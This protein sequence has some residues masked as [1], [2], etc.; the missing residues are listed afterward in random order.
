MA[1]NVIFAEQELDFNNGVHTRHE[2]LDFDKDTELTVSWDGTEWGVFPQDMGGP[3]L[4]GNA[5]LIGAGDDTGEP[6]AIASI[7]AELAGNDTG[8]TQ[9]TAEDNEATSHT[10]AIYQTVEDEPQEE[11][12]IVIK[13]YSG[14]P[15]EY[16]GV[17]KVMFN[18]ADG[19]KRVYS[20]GEALEG[21]S[22]ELDFSS[23]DQTVKAAEGTL[24][25]SAVIKKPETLV[26]ENIKSGVSVAGVEG[27]LIGDGE[28][29]T[30]ALDMSDGD[31]V[32]EP[33]N[34]KLFSSVTVEKPDTLIPENI[35]EGVDIAG[36]IGTLVAGGGGS[37]VVM[38]TGRVSGSISGNVKVTH[39]LGVIPDVILVQAESTTTS[40]S[41]K[42]VRHACGISSAF[43]DAMGATPIVRYSVF[44]CCSTLQSTYE[45][46]KSS[47]TIEDKY[48]LINSATDTTFYLGDSANG[49]RS[50]G[51][52]NWYAIGGLT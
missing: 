5:A 31:M 3:Y 4:I 22:I 27:S 6:F 23:G 33:S 51:Y 29:V 41:D 13:N 38:A 36:I 40:S 15:I 46:Y 43:R 39:N 7:S 20:K 42:Y 9:I 26:A 21:V 19:G 11:V 16:K 48:T 37:K 32:I 14:T 30:V 50:Q 12:G 8:T 2:Y 47:W 17:D 35:A 24:V 44:G 45:C 52:Y 49:Y 28:E 34:G 18:T 10:V 1:E 25:K